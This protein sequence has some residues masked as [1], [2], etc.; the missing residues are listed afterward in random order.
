MNSADDFTSDR[1]AYF[2]KWTTSQ[3]LGV[4][5]LQQKDRAHKEFIICCVLPYEMNFIFFMCF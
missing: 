2:L 1:G 3:K 5:F 4:F